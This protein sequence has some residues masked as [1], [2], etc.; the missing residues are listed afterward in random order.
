MKRKI[1]KIGLTRFENTK[2]KMEQLAHDRD[3]NSHLRQAALGQTR[4]MAL[5]HDGWQVER[6]SDG[7]VAHLREVGLAAH[8]TARLLM[9]GVE[10]GERYHLAHISKL[11]K[12]TVFAQ[13]FGSSRSSS[14]PV[15]GWF[16]QSSPHFL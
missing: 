12:I 4:I 1:G 6:R 7:G 5:R 16:F 13:Q 10:T 11:A 14:V 3:Q 15:A 8:R 2:G 9:A